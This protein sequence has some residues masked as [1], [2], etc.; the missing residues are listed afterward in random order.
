[1]ALPENAEVDVQPK[2]HDIA[3]N[4]GLREK[5][6]HVQEDVVG[7]QYL[8]LAEQKERHVAEEKG[9]QAIHGVEQLAAALQHHTLLHFAGQDDLGECLAAHPGQRHHCRTPAGTDRKAIRQG[10]DQVVPKAGPWDHQAARVHH[11]DAVEVVDGHWDE[12]G[13]KPGANVPVELP[14]WAR[15]L[16]HGFAQGRRR[17]LLGPAGDLGRGT[18]RAL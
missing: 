2:G 8:I 15:Q 12:E 1:M 11:H 4:D 6:A 7:R 10:V 14:G 5:R 18:V 13:P 9:K 16:P 3:G 17:S